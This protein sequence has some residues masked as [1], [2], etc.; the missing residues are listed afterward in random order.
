LHER[1][2]LPP[3]A[4]HL[5]PF[6]FEIRRPAHDERDPALFGDPRLGLEAMQRARGY[7]ERRLPFDPVPELR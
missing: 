7:G 6:L 2:F 1:V 5:P 3:V 4:C